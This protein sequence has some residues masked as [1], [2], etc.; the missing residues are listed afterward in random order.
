[1]LWF[2]SLSNGIAVA[3]EVKDYLGRVRA[4]EYTSKDRTTAATA[5]SKAFPSQRHRRSTPD[6]S[7]RA[8]EGHARQTSATGVP[9]YEDLCGKVPP[10]AQLPEAQRQAMYD[11]WLQLGQPAT[12]CARPA[13]LEPSTNSVYT[14]EGV[15]G[16]DFRALGI[17]GPE[18]APAVL[19]DGAAMFARSLL[20]AGTLLGASS[21][22]ALGPGNFQVVYSTDG[23][24]VLIR[25]ETTDGHGALQ[26]KATRCEQVRNGGATYTAVPPELAELWLRMAILGIRTWPVRDA[27]HDVNGADRYAFLSEDPA[28]PVVATGV[29]TMSIPPHCVLHT[30]SGDLS[31]E[32]LGP[33][34]I[35]PDR[36]FALGPRQ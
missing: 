1:M 14:I 9:T 12:G 2:V 10:G 21:R 17:A 8:E 3:P 30:P 25:S 28:R 6:G 29:C 18:H 24:W 11:A 13:T 16:G 19:L 31:S 7:H 20:V 35:N 4:G 5:P 22:Y 23:P 36:I 33:L 27:G 32:D 34:D 15:C 26:S